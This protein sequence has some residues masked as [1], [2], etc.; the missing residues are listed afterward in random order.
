M[1]VTVECQ[2]RPAGSKP[3]A[4]RRAG[5]IP[6]TLYGHKGSES[7]PLVLDLAAVQTLL[8]SAV[9]NNTPIDLKVTDEGFQGIA[10]LREVQFHPYHD[11]ILHLS[12]FAIGSQASVEVDV[13]LHFEG[14]PI[15]VKAGGSI[16]ILMNQMRVK[17]P[18][19]QVVERLNIDISHLDVGKG[20][21]VGDIALP[22]GASAVSDPT[23]LVVHVLAG[24]KAR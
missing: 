24:R 22:E 2:T 13:P 6:A 15:G 21:H 14:T 7:I 9:P 4:M 5:K 1:Q 3:R 18:P 16:E 10:L 8:R 23:P 19:T 17:C 11:H 12:F 20:I